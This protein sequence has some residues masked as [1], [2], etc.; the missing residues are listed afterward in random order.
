MEAMD[1]HWSALLERLAPV[2]FWGSVWGL[3]EATAGHA[4]HLLH[5]PGLAGAVMLP[6]AVVF[7]SRAFAA[8]GREE[9]I[10]LT[11]CVAAAL[12]LLDLLVPGRNLL[13]VVNPA[14]FILLEALAV[15][16]V[17]AAFKAA[18]VIRRS[19]PLAES[20]RG[21]AKPRFEGRP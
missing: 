10:F 17:R 21:R 16:G 7:M 3:W 13:A 5:I 9:T 15:T 8:T 1:N 12:K 4:V 19:G 11:G 18:G 2:L 20:E 14:Q 6:A